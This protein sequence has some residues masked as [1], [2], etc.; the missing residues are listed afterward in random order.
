MTDYFAVMGEARRPWLDAEELK[1]RFLS[2]SADCHPDRFHSGSPVEKQS[3]AQKSVEHNA[4]YQCLRE[5]KDRLRHLLEL[6]T[7]AK[8]S[9]IER[10]SQE[11]MDASLEVTRLCRGAD[12]F[13]REKERITSPLLQVELFERGQEWVTKINELARAIDQRR[14]E[15]HSRLKRLDES[16]VASATAEQRRLELLPPL[17]EI[18]RLLSYYERWLGQLRNR[19]VALSI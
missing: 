4:A 19:H 17:E 9:D 1:K 15:L 10:I 14:E 3:A 2:L 6:E 18:Y 5:P 13:L 7:G 16:W 11:L 8:P 12:D